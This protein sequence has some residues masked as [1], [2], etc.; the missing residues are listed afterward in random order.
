M[1]TYHALY[2]LGGEHFWRSFQ[3]DDLPHAVDQAVDATEDEEE[4]LS[5]LRVA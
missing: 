2:E 4:L 5:L 3:A 1:A